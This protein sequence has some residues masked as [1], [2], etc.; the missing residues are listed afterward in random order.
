MDVLT[1]AF[2]ANSIWSIQF[3]PMSS[4]ASTVPLRNGRY[5]NHF[6]LSSSNRLISS[7]CMNVGRVVRDPDST[8]MGVVTVPAR[9][10]PRVPF[11]DVN[12]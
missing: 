2:H 6:E 11:I 1:S 9:N 7:G 10:T 4:L 12:L 5:D 8:M 3:G